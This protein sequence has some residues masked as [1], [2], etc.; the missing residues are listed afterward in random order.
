MNIIKKPHNYLKSDP[1]QN[2]G[3]VVTMVITYFWK[4]QVYKLY[5]VVMEHRI[6]LTTYEN[7]MV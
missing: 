7:T 1:I 5:A 2:G 4:E 6:V 3:I